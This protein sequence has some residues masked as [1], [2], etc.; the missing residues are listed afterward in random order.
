[1]PAPSRRGDVPLS[2]AG[3]RNPSQKQTKFRGCERVGW[4]FT[5]AA[6]DIIWRGCPS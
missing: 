2:L 6:V 4:A 1:M 5:F 3:I